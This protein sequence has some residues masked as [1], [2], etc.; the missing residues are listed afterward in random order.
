[1][2]LIV[3]KLVV[4]FK[5]LLPKWQNCQKAKEEENVVVLLSNFT[6]NLFKIAVKMVE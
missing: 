2:Y 4:L 3:K 1:M 5:I 6:V